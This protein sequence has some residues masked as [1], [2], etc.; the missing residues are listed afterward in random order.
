MQLKFDPAADRLLWNLRTFGG[1]MFSVW[2]TRRMLR[3]LWPPLQEQV[4]R[5]AIAHLM[6]HATVM[7]EAREMLGQAARDRPLQTAQFNT[8]FDSTS[9]ARPLGLEP[10]LPAG[11]KLGPGA[12]NGALLL[13]LNEGSGRSMTL[14]LSDDLSTA[15]LRLLDQALKDADWGLGPVAVPAA[16]ETPRPVTLN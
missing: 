13:E 11:F 12:Q 8:P 16:A 7:P 15:L 2:L 5:R 6:P 1:E 14:Q 10:L 3:L 4:T 9:V